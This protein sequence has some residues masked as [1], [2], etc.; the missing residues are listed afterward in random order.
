MLRPSAVSAIAMIALVCSSPALAGRADVPCR[1]CYVTLPTN[2]NLV[3]HSN[4]TP[5]PWGLVSV[6]VRDYGNN[7]VPGA[8]VVCDFSQ[9]PDLRLAVAQP[10]PGMT[11]DCATKTV[12]AVTNASGV[13]RFCVVGC[14]VNSGA[15]PGATP[16]KGTLL[17]DGIVIGHME[18]A[19]LDQTG[20]DGLS[21]S[22]L[23]AWIADFLSGQQFGRSDYD[24]NGALG[25]NDM[26][27]WV[28]CFLA[29]GSVHGA[30]SLPGGLCP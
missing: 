9:C 18:V 20:G 12:R 10:Y 15:S 19:A 7:L 22:D 14:A 27:I 28:R 16:N 26:A 29:A 2:V 13:A 3:G 8:T 21:A 5:D 4:G 1:I 23:S 25:A 24:A 17:V 30:A 11:V 6:T